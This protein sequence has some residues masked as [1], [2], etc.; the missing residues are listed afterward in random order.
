MVR[1]ARLLALPGFRHWASPPK[2]SPR[3][4]QSATR[5]PDSHPTGLPPARADAH[6]QRSTAYTINHPVSGRTPRRSFHIH[7]CDA[8]LVLVEC[9]T[10]MRQATRQVAP[11]PSS[12]ADQLPGLV[13]V[14]SRRVSAPL[15]DHDTVTA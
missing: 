10:L 13:G 8:G 12:D 1:T 4:R 6:D 3:Q 7:V 15:L 11:C 14:R 9:R 2:A 5:P